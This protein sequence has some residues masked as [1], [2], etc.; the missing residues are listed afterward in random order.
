VYFCKPLH[1]ED[2]ED[3]RE[4][5]KLSLSCTINVPGKIPSWFH[6]GQEIDENNENVSINSTQCEHKLTIQHFELADEGEYMIAF[7]RLTSKTSVKIKGI[8]F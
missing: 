7:G 4:K 2:D 1:I 5:M 3:I 8:N 6:D